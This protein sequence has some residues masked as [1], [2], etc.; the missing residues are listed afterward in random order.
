MV[1]VSRRRCLVNAYRR[2]LRCQCFVI[3]IGNLEFLSNISCF[4]FFWSYL[5]ISKKASGEEQ[6]VF[7]LICKE[8]TCCS[9]TLNA[10]LKGYDVPYTNKLTILILGKLL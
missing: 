5:S 8:M 6:T 1:K 3:A 4:G 9:T 10:T 7:V 2:S